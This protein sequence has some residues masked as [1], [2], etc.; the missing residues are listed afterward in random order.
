MSR[1]KNSSS[2]AMLKIKYWTESFTW[3]TNANK[4]F[5]KFNMPSEQNQAIILP[6]PLLS[7]QLQITIGLFLYVS[8][9]FSWTKAERLKQGSQRKLRRGK[10]HK[11]NTITKPFFPFPFTTA[12]PVSASRILPSSEV[13]KSYKQTHS[14]GA[15]NT[16]LAW[17]LSWIRPL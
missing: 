11:Q 4:A 9:F 3:E 17:S 13:T 15:C 10:P 16:L 6:P 1:K 14:F 2:N 12:D 8:W 7:H 5:W